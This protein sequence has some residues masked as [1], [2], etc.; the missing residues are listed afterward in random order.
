MQV[1]PGDPARI[2]VHPVTGLYRPGV[3]AYEVIQ[4]IPAAFGRTLANPQHGTGGLPQ[5]VIENY[6]DYL[7]PLYSLPLN[8]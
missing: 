3:T 8:R 7:R 1:A 2:P 6:Q 4:D 5:I